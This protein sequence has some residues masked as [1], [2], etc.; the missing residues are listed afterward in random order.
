MHGNLELAGRKCVDILGKEFK[1]FGVKVARSVGCGQIPFNLSEN[2]AG[3][4]HRHDGERYAGNF[5]VNHDNSC[6]I[7]NKGIK[8]RLK[9]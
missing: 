8:G 9:G 5:F 6:R 3:G 4:R 2:G 1:V 7:E